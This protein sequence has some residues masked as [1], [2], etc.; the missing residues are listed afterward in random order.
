VEVSSKEG[1][2]MNIVEAAMKLK[3]MKARILFLSDE[4]NPNMLTGEL[5]FR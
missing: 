4:T 2:T 3:V 1:E 5:I